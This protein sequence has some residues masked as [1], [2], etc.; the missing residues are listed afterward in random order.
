M[1]MCVGGWGAA[2]RGSG[3]MEKIDNLLKITIPNLTPKWPSVTTEKQLIFIETVHSPGTLL[4][5]LQ[6]VIQSFPRI[7]EVSAAVTLIS[8]MSKLRRRGEVT[9]ARLVVTR[10]GPLFVLRN[11]VPAVVSSDTLGP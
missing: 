3:V 10:S 6:A 8:P 4:S 5:A 9:G 11:S 7:Y 2:G 1:C